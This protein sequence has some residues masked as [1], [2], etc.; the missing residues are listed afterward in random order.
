M[1]RARHTAG[2]LWS[3]AFALLLAGCGGGGGDRGNQGAQE[4]PPTS[5]GPPT[6]P[7]PP[8][9]PDPPQEPEPPAASAGLDARPSNTTCLAP[10]RATGSTTIGTQRVF[11]NLRFRDA[12]GVSRNPLLLIQAPRDRSRWFVAE[13]FGAVKVFDNNPAVTTSSMFLD[14]GARVESTCAECGLQIGRAHV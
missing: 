13:R 11:P 14:I 9:D 8:D 12:A 3:L 7:D 1:P 10:A 6:T 2:M 4:P 5:P